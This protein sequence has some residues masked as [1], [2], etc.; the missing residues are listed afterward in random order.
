MTAYT[1]LLVDDEIDFVS[2]LAER[3]Q[4]RD[5]N[6]VVATDGYEALEYIQQ[7]Q[8]RVVVLDIMMP[9]LD[10]LDVL[11]QIKSNYPSIQVILLTGRGGTQE[12]IQGM[13]LGAFDYIVKPIKLEILLEKMNQAL[14]AVEEG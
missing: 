5:F 10:G 1:V 13:R 14:K 6:A 11:A 9:G 2:T 8:P 3:L 7:H 12:G 4:M